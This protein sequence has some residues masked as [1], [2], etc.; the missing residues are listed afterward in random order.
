MIKKILLTSLSVY[1]I[2][3]LLITYTYYNEKIYILT[4]F[5]EILYL[6]LGP[7]AIIKISPTLFFLNPI[8]SDINYLSILLILLTLG[9]LI[10][11]AIC[12][13][14]SK[15]YKILFVFGLCFWFFHGIIAIGFYSISV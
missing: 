3:L 5:Q 14:R 11:G 9:A 13:N 4:Y 2:F 7:I 15:I 1:L 6:T 8:T 10:I 12:F